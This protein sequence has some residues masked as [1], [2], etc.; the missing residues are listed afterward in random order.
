MNI[1]KT[2][3]AAGAAV[4]F[5]VFG[6]I[7][8]AKNTSPPPPVHDT[9]TL[10]QK[11]DT[12][13][14]KSGLVLYLPF[15]GSFADSSGMNNTVTPLNG[16]S[17][18]YD[19]HG[20]G[21]SAFNS[22]GNG[23]VLQVTNNGSYAVDTAFTVSLDFKIN[24]PAVFYGGYDF[25]GLQCFV[26]IVDYDNADGPTFNCGLTVPSAPQ[27]FDFGVNGSNSSCSS[28]VG[29]PLDSANNLNS[30]FV[31]QIGA[32]YNAICMYSKGNESIYINGVLVGSSTGGSPAALF[33]S[34]AT[35]IVG[36]WWNGISGGASALENLRGELDEV[37]FY[38]RTLNAKQIAWLSR[39][40]QLNSNAQQRALED[41]S[42]GQLN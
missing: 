18:G 41:G 7:G 32:W 12:P 37:R 31:P 39:N 23:T 35:F 33:C 25:S 5:L 8:C 1:A 21:N 26:S 6:S 10:V 29:D 16:A 17:L 2:I 3:P 36:G 15:N 20:Y 9:I 13:D 42:T 30:K 4:L 28:S 34:N 22:T 19:M 40:F 14:V 11:L 24:S 27:Y 38:N